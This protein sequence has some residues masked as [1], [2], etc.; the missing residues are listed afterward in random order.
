MLALHATDRILRLIDPLTGKEYARLTSPDNRI[1]KALRFSPDGRWLAA[2]TEANVQ[3]WDL[4]LL[5]H[6]LAALKLDW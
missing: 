3:L 1:L 5:R 4:Q 2:A 6:E